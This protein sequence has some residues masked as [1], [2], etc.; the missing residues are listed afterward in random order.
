MTFQPGDSTDRSNV[1]EEIRHALERDLTEVVR[2]E[3]Q[4]DGTTRGIYATDSSNYRQIPL[5]VVFPVDEED[6]RRIVEVCRRHNAPI[7]G[8]GAGTSLAG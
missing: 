8:R 2:G 4:F 3:V 7:L 6:V 1:N 5:G